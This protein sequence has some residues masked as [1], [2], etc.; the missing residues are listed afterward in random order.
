MLKVTAAIIRQKGKLLI[1]QRGAGGHCAFLWEFPGGKLEP[2]E[3]KEECLIREC[4]EELGIQI[5]VGSIFA[6]TTYQYPDRKISF[7][8]FNAEIISGELTPKVHQQVQW[9][10]PEEL[11]NYDFC[12]ADTEIVNRLFETA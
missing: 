2:G 10:T 12:P 7:T 5:A 11:K 6:E 9:I 4:E 3:S 1:C 8:F